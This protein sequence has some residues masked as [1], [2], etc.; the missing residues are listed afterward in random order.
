MAKRP[1]VEIRRGR[2]RR[3]PRRTTPFEVVYDRVMHASRNGCFLAMCIVALAA[4][5]GDDDT[6]RA[7]AGGTDGGG[8]VDG[9]TLPDGGIGVDASMPGTP[10]DCEAAP[11]YSVKTGAGGAGADWANALPDLPSTLERGATY[12]LADGTYAAHTF[13]DVERGVEVITIRKA[14]AFDH[15][16]DVGWSDTDG[17]EQAFFDGSLSFARDHYLIDGAARDE[18]D[19]LDSSSYGIHASSLYIQNNN[20]PPGA[21]HVTARYCDLGGPYDQAFS[22]G[23]GEAVYLGGFDAIITDITVSRSFLHN[24]SFVQCAGAD[25]VTVEYTAFAAGWAKEAV[26]GQGT[27]RNG[28]LR[29]NLFYNASQ[30]DPED[31]TS[32]TTA[33]IAIWDGEAGAFD[34]WDIY[35]N[36]IWNDREISHCCGVIVVGGDGTSFVGAPASNV[37]VYNNTIAGLGASAVARIDVNGG[38]G[39]EVS[40]NIWYDCAGRTGAA[41]DTASNGTVTSDPFV[42]YAGFDFRL[43]SPLPGTALPSPYDEDA[44]GIRR[45]GDGVFDRGAFEYVAP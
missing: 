39:N 9:G 17:D 11:C 37:H 6:S 25:G 34:N 3:G 27:C 45:G 36:V 15:G 10:T 38:T 35:G 29:H 20:L 44:F 13:E 2:E 21:D 19:W 40:N 22:P 1:R 18:A 41:P 5:G 28:V 14:T 32:G 30:R 8:R 26:R 12:F 42:D 23:Q 24:W 4:C 16:T 43:A 33:E 31:P 7:D